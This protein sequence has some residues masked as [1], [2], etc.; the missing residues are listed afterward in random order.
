MVAE[1]WLE[2]M[3]TDSR[4]SRDETKGNGGERANGDER[5]MSVALDASTQLVAI[6]CQALGSRAPSFQA[7]LREVYYTGHGGKQ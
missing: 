4:K 1:G 3:C 7:F 2:P 6:G 5:R